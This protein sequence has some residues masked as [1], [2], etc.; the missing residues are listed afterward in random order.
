MNLTQIVKQHA[1]SLGFSLV[2]IT[3]PE[4]LPHAE[5]FEHWLEHGRHGEMAYL[6]TPHSRMCRAH[7]SSILPECQSVLVLGMCYPAPA[8]IKAGSEPGSDLNGSTLQGR[9]AA[10]AWG[11]DYHTT[12]PEKLR[13]L[14][15]M[16]EAELGHPVPNRWY[17]DTGPLLERELAQRAGL[18]WIGKNTCLINPD[19]GSYY[20]LA[21]ILL[22]VALEPDQPFTPDRCGTCTRCMVAC[23]TGC[24]LPDR[25]LDA[26]RCISYLTIELKGAIPVDLRP[27]MQNWVF[28]CDVCQQVCPWN[29]FALPIGDDANYASQT[30]TPPL[31]LEE[32]NLSVG[33]FSQKYGGSPLRR[34]KR[35]G[36]LRNVV[37]A[38]GNLGEPAALP[39]LTRLLTDDAEPLVRS[40]AAWSLGE[41]TT[42]SSRQILQ[43]ALS[44]EAD[45]LVRLEIQAALA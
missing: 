31:L 16:I 38:L 42:T 32:V 30:Q 33:D 34:A 39:G 41:F 40:H 29:R 45:P 14:V 28:G 15:S 4:L 20:L 35:R 25:T 23:P 5:V 2:G 22:G 26:R 8:P 10:Y 37:I 27:K 24:I 9:I 19:G 1:L 44:I 13:S 11:R 12:L 18:G 7:P 43:A 36:Y 21:E 6:A 3:T 17:T